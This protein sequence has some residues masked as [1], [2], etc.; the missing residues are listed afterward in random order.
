M[1]FQ[2]AETLKTL[3]KPQMLDEKPGGAPPQ[4]AR[5]LV[6]LLIAWLFLLADLLVVPGMC[7]WSQDDWG[8]V[9]V[10]ALMGIIVAQFAMLPAWLAWGGPPFWIR[11]LAVSA[12]GMVYVGAWL[13][14][15]AIGNWID[16]RAFQRGIDSEAFAAALLLPPVILALVIPLQGMRII[17]GW[18]LGIGPVHVPERPLAISDLLLAMALV[19]AA[20]TCAR[21]AMRFARDTTETQFWAGLAIG[22]ACGAVASAALVLPVT[23]LAF[24]L[25]SIPLGVAGIAVFSILATI[26]LLVTASLVFGPR[27]MDLWELSGLAITGSIG[28][29]AAAATFWLARSVGYRLEAGRS[30]VA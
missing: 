16:G 20:L 11:L 28:M 6:W 26:A 13:L 7:I 22:T 21:L 8:A 30:L 23:W 25:K 12:S 4:G 19:A 18:R 9:F 27:R 24:R 29:Y 15:I 5:A 10:Y 17:F 14:G 1:E 2:Q 3:P